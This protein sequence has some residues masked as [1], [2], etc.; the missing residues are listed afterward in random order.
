MTTTQILVGLGE[1]QVVQGDGTFVCIGLGSCVGLCVCDPEAKVSG[2][3]HIMLPKSFEAAQNTRPAKFA[4]SGVVSLIDMVERL[5][6]NRSN[7]K[8]ALVGGAQVVHGKTTN[9]MMEFGARNSLMVQN[10]LDEMKIP[11]LGSDLGGNSGRT[12][13]YDTRTSVVMVRTPTSGD[14]LICRLQ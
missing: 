5:G 11:L 4:D 7:L 12:M 1:I 3:A 9:A 2:V 13:T 10:I 8:A 6:A 14:R